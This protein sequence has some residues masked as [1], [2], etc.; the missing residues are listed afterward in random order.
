MQLTNKDVNE[1][2]EKTVQK[3][4]HTQ[5]QAFQRAKYEYCRVSQQ[6]QQNKGYVEKNAEGAE[7]RYVTR[8]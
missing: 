2:R 6:N 3:E 5:N 8:L 1:T 7:D 4:I